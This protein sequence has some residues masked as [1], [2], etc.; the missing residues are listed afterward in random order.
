VLSEGARKAPRLATNA[1]PVRKKRPC[2]V[3]VVLV[4]VP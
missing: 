2:S 4:E 1:T 3:G